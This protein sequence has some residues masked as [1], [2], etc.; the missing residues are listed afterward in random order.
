MPV[1]GAPPVAL[2]EEHR[3]WVS[4]AAERMARQLSRA[5]YPVV[6]DPAVVVPAESA[7]PAVPSV[8]SAQMVLDLAVQMLIDDTWKGL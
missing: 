1:T 6:G 5:G 3:D 2:P 8:A 7:A 4:A